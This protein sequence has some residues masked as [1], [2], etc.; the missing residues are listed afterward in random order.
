MEETIQSG[1]PYSSD[2]WWHREEQALSRKSREKNSDLQMCY[3]EF[4]MIFSLALY[5]VELVE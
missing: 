3:S 2:G 1:I 4:Q 5:P